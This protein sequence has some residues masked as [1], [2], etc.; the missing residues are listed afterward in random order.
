[1]GRISLFLNKSPNEQERNK[2]KIN[3]PYC[4]PASRMDGQLQEF[5]Q[6]L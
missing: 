4:H 1:M 2:L 3:Y 5:A 6:N